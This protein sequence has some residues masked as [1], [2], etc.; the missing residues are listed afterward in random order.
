[1]LMRETLPPAAGQNPG[2]QWNEMFPDLPGCAVH[3]DFYIQTTCSPILVGGNIQPSDLARAFL[4]SLDDV[5]GKVYER[6]PASAVNAWTEV[7]TGFS[8]DDGI[9]AVGAANV[10][11]NL[12][13]RHTWEDPRRGTD[14]ARETVRP[15]AALRNALVQ[16]TQ[17]DPAL[18][19]AI[20]AGSINM[21][22]YLSYDQDETRIGSLVPLTRIVDGTAQPPAF[23]GYITDI[24]FDDIVQNPITAA[25]A[26]YIKLNNKTFAEDITP[27]ALVLAEASEQIGYGSG[28]QVPVWHE[29]VVWPSRGWNLTD[30]DPTTV[31]VQWTAAVAAADKGYLVAEVLPGTAFRT[32]SQL[33]GIR[34]P[35]DVAGLLGR[36]SSSESLVT[37]AGGDRAM[38]ARALSG[39]NVPVKLL[40]EPKVARDGV[41]DAIASR[42]AQSM[43]LRRPRAL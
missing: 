6:I 25:E 40:K 41:E 28:D 10:P 21:Q 29:P 42:L 18:D 23:R 1:M 2:A 26:R 30:I 7:K 32:V 38:V 15:V 35:Q 31:R 39:S 5:A 24:F 8:A 16:F 33:A 43:R 36:P 9:V 12:H 4:V 34:D 3:L 13:I 20:D 17:V 37:E 22:V 19:I 11:V 27:A 14:K